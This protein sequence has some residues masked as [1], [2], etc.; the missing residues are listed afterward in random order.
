[1]TLSD[2]LSRFSE[3]VEERDGYVVHCPAHDDSR[4]SLR[5]A[6]SDSG[7]VILRCRRGCTTGKV[8]EALNITFRDLFDVKPG[9]GVKTTSSK[10]EEV[11]PR[12]VAALAVYLGETAERLQAQDGPDGLLAAQALVYLEGRFGVDQETAK[13]LGLGVDPGGT[14]HAFEYLGRP[15]R[16]V[17]RLVVPFRDFD[18][19]ARGVQARDLT[20]NDPVRWA[21]ATNPEGAAWTKVG[22]LDLRTGLD[23]VIVTEGPGDGLTAA[24]VGYDAVFI[25]G[26]ALAGNAEAVDALVPHLT[27]R[28]IVVAGDGDTAGQ[29][30]TERVADR[31]AGHGLQ[32][33][34]LTIPDGPADRD[35]SG[36]R[37]HDPEGF[38]EAFHRAVRD[39]RLVGSYAP[40]T[41]AAPAPVMADDDY[42]LTDLGNAERLHDH[43][44]GLVRFAPETGFY[45]WD[46]SV[47]VV[48]RFDA[49]RTTAHEVVRSMVKVGE[50][51]ME[52]ATDPEGKEAKEAK[53]LIGWG[54]HS[55]S[56]RSI[57]SMVR[58]LSA[59][60]GV[61]IDVERLDGRHDLLAFRNGTV[62]LRTGDLR[63]H[64]PADLMTRKID[65][66]YDPDATSPT[67]DYFLGSVFPDHP[68]LPAFVQRLVG[69]GITGHTREQC[70]AVLW[71]TGSNGK[72]VFTDT[73]TSVF[74]S[75]TTTTPF[76]TF[77]TKP[78]GGI[79][80]DLAALKGARLVMA[81]E[82]AQGKPMAEE[83]IKR[84]TGRD[85]IAARFMRREFFEFSPTFLILL[86]TNYKP[87]FRGQDEGLWRRVKL[88]PWSRYFAPTERDHYLP[89]KLLAEA[90]GIVAWAVKGA[91]DW[92]ARG[93][94]EPPV[95]KEATKSYRE[96]SDN[97]QGFLPGVLVKETGAEML[98]AD[99]YLAYREWAEEEGFL[100]SAVWTRRTFYGALEERGIQRVKKEK[101]VVLVGVRKDPTHHG[102][103][104][105]SVPRTADPAPAQ[106]PPDTHTP[107]APDLDDV[108]G[109]TDGRD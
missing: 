16:R 29:T 106:V 18:G 43:L 75:I 61:A 73:L 5:V 15:Y 85:K 77:E 91:R 23:Y 84:V 82:G 100:S 11:G 12:E 14:A 92:Y 80:N 98:G 108:F 13:A 63:P 37:T 2:L 107:Q 24:G 22:V 6:L 102:H 83:V 55:Q 81:S 50:E 44:G 30:F 7:N 25:R 36:W 67:W 49:V 48:D 95:V 53:R 90:P 87:N 86:A 79:P 71:G 21:G 70:F 76:S 56:T 10:T 58:E 31:L 52:A 105:A 78:N 59:M 68:D 40:N 46:G 72:S 26:A 62:D 42:A 69:Y 104:P 97:L 89:E 64:D 45:L 39:A 19:V 93:L 88:V 41:T 60:P 109:G 74:R 3:V 47:W 99:A 103:G 101:G 33:H 28:K 35:L 54:L 17:P 34:T 9:E 8:V 96:T 65:V 66:D 4:P 57:D 1:M 94:Q 32:V 20:G 27:G 38:P 51:R